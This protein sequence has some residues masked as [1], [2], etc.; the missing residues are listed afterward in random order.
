[1]KKLII[2]L[3]F[4][5]VL[6]AGEIKPKSTIREVT[7]YLSGA[8]VTSEAAVSLPQGV[9]EV[10]LTDLSPLID[11]NSI[12]VSGLKDASILSISYAVNHIA[13]KA[14]TGKIKLL[15]YDLAEKRRRYAILQ[16]T[17]KGL[18]EEESL[19]NTNK[20]L[21]GE[22][23][24]LTLTQV[25]TFA[26]YYR[27][28]NSAL[29]TEIYDA[30]VAAE[31]L[32][33]DINDVNQE[34]GKLLNN[35]QQQRGEIWVKIDSPVAMILNL[36]TKYTVSNAGWFPIY[37]IKTQGIKQLLDIFYKAHVY[38]QTGEDWTDVKVTLS[39]GDPNINNMKP[40]V[41]PHYL[42]FVQYRQPGYQAVQSYNY[43]YNPTI[44]KVSGVV[45]D[46]Q[47][48]P[49]PGMNIIEQGTG[50]MV[51]TDVDGRYNINITSGKNLE[52]SYIGMKS[53]TL[54][55]YAQQMNVKMEEDAAVLEEVVV[56]GYGT[57]SKDKF[58]AS[59]TT[60]TTE[61]IETTGTG[62]V[63]EM[64]V[65]NAVFKITKPYTITNSGEIA[66]IAIDKFTLPAA[67]EYF[68]AP[69]VNQNVF[70]TAKLKEWEKFDLLPGEANVYFEGSYAGKTFIDPLQTTEEL[71][72]S[73]G[74][75]PAVIVERK[76]IDDL[77]AKSF[78]GGTRIINKNYEISVRNNKASDIE[79]VMMDRIPVSQNKEIKIDD[80]NTGGA[81]YDDNK[82]L[83]TWKLNLKAKESTKRQLSY[84]VKYPKEKRV[85]L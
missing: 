68:T 77:K 12:Q 46:T 33:R 26:K 60:V 24:S 34:L 17:I 21:N 78:L 75:D 30:T 61:Q 84:K 74:V 36:V 63:K 20:K 65:T 22:Q 79:I 25:T 50:N 6:L 9:S 15:E 55:I 52:Y 54:P 18:K 45:V 3:L 56:V 39:T 67:Y 51:Q 27:E 1:M 70:L 83:L 29:Q 53:Q 16:N 43:K 40:E 11:Q 66:V 38:Q 10:L 80:V 62:D 64:G 82:G 49:L 4:P 23:Q 72:I 73:L 13:K 47:G 5:S 2:L 31:K 32:N 59:T 19:L 42:N 44:K 81:E 58:N 8:Q 69:L 28:R 57:S 7:V 41:L 37:D 71:T 85:N 35:S 48:L 14:D 76:Q